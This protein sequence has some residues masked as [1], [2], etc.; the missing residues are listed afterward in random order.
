[1]AAVNKIEKYGLQERVLALTGEGKTTAVIADIITSELNQRDAISQPTVAR[2][3]KSVRQERSEQTRDIVQKHLEI[4][5]PADLDAL[6][7]IEKAVLGIFRN[8][9]L[10]AG[11]PGEEINPE[12]PNPEQSADSSSS[13]PFDLRTRLDAGMKV[14]KIIETKLRYA[15]ILENPDAHDASPVDLDEFRRGLDE[16]KEHVDGSV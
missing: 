10:P 4:S 3:L 12:Q 15:G 7:E 13:A 16:M 6:E 14:I 11:V 8:Q 9:A 5:L 2:W 1:M